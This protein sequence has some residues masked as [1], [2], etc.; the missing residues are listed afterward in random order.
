[1]HRFRYY[2]N[3]RN[4][5]PAWPL[6][7]FSELKVRVHQTEQEKFR[8]LQLVVV[9]GRRPNK[10]G[11][12]KHVFVSFYGFITFNKILCSQ[13]FK[14]TTTPGPR[15]VRGVVGVTSLELAGLDFE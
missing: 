14:K 4:F 7:A 11:K 13:R 1:M 3:F 2:Q 8:F 12:E 10:N 5:P 15:G 6:A 9:V